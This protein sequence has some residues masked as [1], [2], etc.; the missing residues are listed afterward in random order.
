MKIILMANGLI[1]LEISKSLVGF[2]E[3]ILGLFVPASKDQVLADEI[4]LASQVSQNKI[5]IANKDWT[6][7]D[8][9]TLNCLQPDIILAV[10]WPYILPRD[11]FLSPK[12]GAINFHMAFLPYNRGK[13]PNVWPI[14]DG[15]PAGISM[16]YIDE[17]IDSGPIIAR[18]QIAVEVIDTAESLF[19]KQAK[20][21][22]K[23]FSEVW[24][25]L[26]KIFAR[27]V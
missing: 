23:L 7:E 24:P 6:S 10:Y 9:A 2:G 5:F 1:G 20:E 11:V 26:K 3:K 8:I 12:N 14:L 15:S 22:P 17:G 21:F 4:I 19:Y 27:R 13:K 16:H 25:S 18:R